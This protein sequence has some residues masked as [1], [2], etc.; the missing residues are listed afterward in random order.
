MEKLTANAL[1]A[2]LDQHINWYADDGKLVREYT[3]ADFKQS[4]EFVNHVAAEA[5]AAGH[6]PDIEIN[7]NKV[8]LSLVTHDAGGITARDA[9]L[10]TTLDQKFGR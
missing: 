4:M 5:E 1:Q 7:Y 6:H 10:A 2:V 3:F 9:E 8:K